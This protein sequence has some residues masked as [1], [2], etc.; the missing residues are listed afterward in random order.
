MN[1]FRSWLD[2]R[3]RRRRAAA[4]LA[5]LRAAG[6]GAASI[7]ADAATSDPD[8]TTVHLALLEKTYPRLP[9]LH[10]PARWGGFGRPDLRDLGNL[11]LL[12]RLFAP[13]SWFP[14]ARPRRH[15]PTV[16]DGLAELER[17]FSRR[18]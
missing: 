11:A 13:R 7:L 9:F 6:P 16:E 5:S 2:G 15:E 14:K 4:V 17:Y 12:H 3:A 18:R 8:P 1:I 10:D